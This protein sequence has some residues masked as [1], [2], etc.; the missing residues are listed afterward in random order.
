MIIVL[1]PYLRFER[2]GCQI[3]EAMGIL[4]TEVFIKYL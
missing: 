1:L 4:E 2:L 3:L